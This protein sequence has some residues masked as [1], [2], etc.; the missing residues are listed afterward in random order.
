MIQ[1]MEIHYYK[2]SIDEGSVW[3]DH[4]FQ[5]VQVASA[6]DQQLALL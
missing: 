6:I 3:Q 5:P 2:I 1:L 4:G